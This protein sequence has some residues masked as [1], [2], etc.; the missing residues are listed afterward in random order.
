MIT[1]QLKDSI[2][3]D[4][5]PG[6]ENPIVVFNSLA[7][8][9]EG[10]V[11]LQTEVIKKVDPLIDIQFFLSDIRHGSIFSDYIKKILIPEVG[12]TTAPPE[13]KGDLLQY[14]QLSQEGAM[15]C[16]VEKEGEVI[17]NE[18][19]HEIK[20]E[21]LRYSEETG[22][23]RNAN[24]RPPNVLKIASSIELLGKS[25]SLLSLSDKFYFPNNRRIK[26]V[27]KI[28]TAIDYAELKIEIAKKINETP[29]HKI[30]KIKIADFLGKSKWKLVLENGEIIKVKILDSE[31]LNKFHFRKETIGSGDTI[32]FDGIVRDV[33]DESDN[34]IDSQYTILKIIMVHEAEHENELDF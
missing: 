8:M 24:F 30:L 17:K 27:G 9:F 28:Y 3:L 16:I 18:K 2:G 26:E 29:I 15:K 23:N 5:S 31:W 32:E 6:A 7:Q 13:A 19:I 33:F 21:I 4:F 20:K 11:T 14:S 22:V 10:I 1:Y 25:T 12:D 34:L